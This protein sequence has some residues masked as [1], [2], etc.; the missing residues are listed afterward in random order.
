MTD[1]KI[2]NVSSWKLNAA[3]KKTVAE[4]VAAGE[5]EK[6]VTRELQ[7]KKA[8]ASKQ[9]KLSAASVAKR[10]SQQQEQSKPAPKGKAKAVAAKVPVLPEDDATNKA[11]YEAVQADMQVIV[12][13]YGE[14]ILAEKPLSI[15]GVAGSGGVQEPFDKS[16]AQQSLTSHG[17]YRASVNM[18]WVNAL[19]SPC[20]DIPMSRK[21]VLDLRDFHYPMGAPKF[22]TERHLEVA[23]AKSD[24]NTDSPSNLQMISPEEVCH[25]TLAGCALAI[26]PHGPNNKFFIISKN[27]SSLF[28]ISP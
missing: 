28:I 5:N 7:L 21:R 27:I 6:T 4:R 17:V 9:R 14:G 19:C 2:T 3:E 10:C 13:H 18:F 25:A 15:T 12:N 8:E 23:I 26:Q 1:Q 11:Y 24:I 20:P 16:K 22:Q